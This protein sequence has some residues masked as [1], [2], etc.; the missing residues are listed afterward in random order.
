MVLTLTVDGR[1]CSAPVGG[2]VLHA[3]REAGVDI[4]TL[5]HMDGLEP[6]AGCRLCLV[7]V[8]G[9]TRPVPACVT[10]VT[11]GMV[12]TT[13]S[14]R[15]HEWRKLLL[16]LLLAERT[17]VCSVCVANG[18]C[19]LQALAVEHGITHLTVPRRTFPTRVDAT[20]SRFLLDHGRCILC[21]RCVRA[22]EEYVWDFMGRGPD[23][24]IVCGL[25]EG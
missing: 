17:H 20:Q 18:R 21:G 24:R 11:E 22:C 9:V 7:E 3:A 1:P 2:T 23:T 5:C 8:Q 19:E 6:Y 12:V 4:P 14:E 13:R 10:E 15:L 25:D 16:E